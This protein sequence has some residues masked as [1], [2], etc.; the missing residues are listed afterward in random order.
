MSLA[1]MTLGASADIIRGLRWQFLSNAI[2]YKSNTI[3]SVASVFMCYTHPI[4]LFLDQVKSLG[5]LY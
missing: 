2:G 1:A 3:I 5:L 4:W